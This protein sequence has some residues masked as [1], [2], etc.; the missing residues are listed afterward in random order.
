M[1]LSTKMLIRQ[2]SAR[3]G[4]VNNPML[5]AD[6]VLNRVY[7]WAPLKDFLSEVAGV[8]LFHS[9]DLDGR[10]YG[11]VNG[12]HHATSWHFDES[13]YSIVFMLQRSDIVRDAPMPEHT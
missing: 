8:P 1:C 6:G 9:T 2:V 7:A 5:P 3:I 12:A 4:F 11:I 13:P 10:V